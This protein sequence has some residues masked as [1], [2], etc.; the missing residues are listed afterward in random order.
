MERQPQRRGNRSLLSPDRSASQ[1][2]GP[3]GFARNSAKVTCLMEL[4]PRDLVRETQP[5]SDSEF[6]A[7]ELTMVH[8]YRTSPWVKPCLSLH[9]YGLPA[10][11]GSWHQYCISSLQRDGRGSNAC[12][13]RLKPPGNRLSQELS[14]CGLIPGLLSLAL[15]SFQTSEA[16]FNTT[17]LYT[18]V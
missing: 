16:L 10:P 7:L 17:E 13:T 18:S 6:Q 3:G 8:M 4:Y 1:T 12:L 5:D 15:C 11:L 2:P 14:P 9:T